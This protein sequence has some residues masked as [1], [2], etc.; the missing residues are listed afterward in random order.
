MHTLSSARRTCIA[1]ESAVECTATVWMP[2]SW[3]ARWIRSAISPRLAIRTLSNM[4]SRI[5]SPSPYSTGVPSLTRMRTTR[6]ARGA[7]TG[8]NVFIASISARVW[9]SATMSPAL[10]NA[11]APGSGAR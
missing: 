11:A 6:P 4:Y 9:P 8:L 10:T 3:Q 2:I 7:R 5:I 1:S